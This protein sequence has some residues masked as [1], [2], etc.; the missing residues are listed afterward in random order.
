MEVAEEL[1]KLGWSQEL[2]KSV[3]QISDLV[4]TG[5]VKESFSYPM[6]A[7]LNISGNSIDVSNVQPSGLN[8]IF[9]K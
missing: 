7:P 2:I 4:K 1:K 5:E 9:I 6:S 8:V 3:E